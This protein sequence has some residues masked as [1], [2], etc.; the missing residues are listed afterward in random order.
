MAVTPFHACGAVRE[1]LSAVHSRIFA[2]ECFGSSRLHLP[3]ADRW[4]TL[5]A[6]A[7]VV[8]G[9]R[10]RGADRG[11]DSPEGRSALPGDVDVLRGWASRRQP[12]SA[13]GRCVT[14]LR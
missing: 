2:S 13:G 10:P 1:D 11:A 3:A 7:G 6:T 8:V 5:P 4:S 12:M 9:A 14:R